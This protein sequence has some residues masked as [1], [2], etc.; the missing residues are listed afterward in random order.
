MVVT[1]IMATVWVPFLAILAIRKHLDE[2][3]TQHFYMAMATSTGTAVASSWIT[4]L[5]GGRWRADPRWIDRL[6]RFLGASW[7]MSVFLS[8]CECLL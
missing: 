3:S 4:L 8:M 6:G 7:M 5:I 1:A 2:M